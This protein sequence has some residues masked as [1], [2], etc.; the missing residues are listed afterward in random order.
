MRTGRSRLPIALAVVVGCLLLLEEGCAKQN[1]REEAGAGEPGPQTV[2]VDLVNDAFRPQTIEAGAGRRLVLE[3]NNKGLSE[4]TFTLP[5]RDVD[6][7][8]D[9]GQ[10]K[11][12][13]VELPDG[14]GELR[15]VCRFHNASG[16]HGRIAYA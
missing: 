7:V 11:T 3:L 4:H 8:L 12:V 9:R 13:S 14:R 10:G 1:T 16:M 15:F 6:V 2:G 5:D